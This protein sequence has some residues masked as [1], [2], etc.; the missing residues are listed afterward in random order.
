MDKPNCY[1]CKWRGSIP[2]D[3]HSS[4]HHPSFG[5]VENNPLAQV[6]GIL[7]SAR[8][9]PFQV[10]S[11]AITVRGNPH[12]IRSGWFNHPF[13]FDPTWLEECTGFEAKNSEST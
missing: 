13:N 7:T 12:G 3:C 6:F 10:Q 8:K 9:I 1:E 11:D 5:K 2:G 4:C